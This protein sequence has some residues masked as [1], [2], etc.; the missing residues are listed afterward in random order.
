MIFDAVTQERFYAKGVAYAPQKY[1]TDHKPGTDYFTSDRKSEWLPDLDQLQK[2]NVNSVRLYEVDPSQDHT[3]FMN[4][5]DKRGM[6][7][8]VSLTRETGEW[9]IL[10]AD[11]P[12]PMCYNGTYGP[13]LFGGAIDTVKQF[14]KFDN[15]MGFVVGNEVGNA[16][17]TPAV[18]T[19]KAVNGYLAL[20]CV[21]ALARDIKSYMKKCTCSMRMVPLIYAATDFDRDFYWTDATGQKIQ[22]NQRHVVSDYLACNLAGDDMVDIYGLN[23]YTW[24]SRTATATTGSSYAETTRDYETSA[25]ALVQTEFGC[26]Q[27]DFISEDPF[28]TNQRTWKQ[29]EALLS[30]G[31][32]DV[33]SGGFAYEYAN[34]ENKYGMVLLPGYKYLNGTEVTQTVVLENGVNLGIEYGK[35][36]G[37]A[38]KGGWSSTD[39]C[40]WKPPTFSTKKPA[41]CPELAKISG[42]L[43]AGDINVRTFDSVFEKD[44]LPA[45]FVPDAQDFKTLACEYHGISD[46]VK[47]NQNCVAECQCDKIVPDA[48][49]KLTTTPTDTGKFYGLFCGTYG[50][51]CS[52]TSA[53]KTTYGGCKDL[54]KMNYLLTTGKKASGDCCTGFV[55]GTGCVS[56]ATCSISPS[57]AEC[58]VVAGTNTAKLIGKVCGFLGEYATS[59]TTCNNLDTVAKGCTGEV[60]A[61]V[62]VN[63][64]FN[65]KKNDQGTGECCA[66]LG[67]DGNPKCVKGTLP[68]TGPTTPPTNAP[69]TNAPPPT[70]PTAPTT[71]PT[72]AP[73]TTVPST[74]I[75]TSGSSRLVVSVFAAISFF[76]ALFQL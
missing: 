19:D 56:Q 50:D 55:D 12:S 2:F 27:G 49:C 4:E 41:V 46:V 32:S 48:D 13:K 8:I 65:F 75:E 68:P 61:Q 7:A 45:P 34:R 59:D 18:R 15:T 57:T 42:F 9:G 73:T 24:C 3:E 16:V 72:A 69:P 64:W 26:N 38:L 23:Q 5:L 76:T 11:L 22:G 71:K 67:A 43:A 6:Y 31:M 51:L 58:P 10:R 66:S 47:G 20:P 70:A 39:Y 54:D 21:K 37:T 44:Q 25:L 33:F 30:S 1:G 35:A 74:N 40:T 28:T 52:D 29:I 17:M 14:S 62:V 53:F 60:K 36:V 63:A